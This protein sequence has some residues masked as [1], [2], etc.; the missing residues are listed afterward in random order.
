MSAFLTPLWLEDV[1]G[2]RW[3]VAAPFRYESTLLRGVVVVPAG[4]ETNLASIPRVAWA[5]LPQSGKWNRAAV[6]HDA[7]YNG[8]LRTEDGTRIHLI[9]P[10]CDKLF[11]EA[12][13]LAGVNRVLAGLMYR[14]VARFGRTDPAVA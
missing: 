7:G 1:D 8:C 3:V 13:Q 11:L 4:T 10:L 6:L 14:A 2:R 9:K 5:L 12:M